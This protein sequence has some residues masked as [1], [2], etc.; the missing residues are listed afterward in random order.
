VAL[1]TDFTGVPVCTGGAL[2][3]GAP[4]SLAEREADRFAIA[5][6]FR[7]ESADRALARAR[8]HAGAPSERAAAALGAAAF[9]VGDDVFFGRNQFAPD[10]A[11]GGFLLRHELGHVQQRDRDTVRCFESFEHRAFGDRYL[12]EL[13]EFLRTPEGLAWAQ[14]MG[15][16]AAEVLAA[17][18]TD[19][20]RPGQRIHLRPG[21]DVTPGDAIALMGDFYGSIDALANAKLGELRDRPGNAAHKPGILDVIDR[22]ERVGKS[23]AAENVDYENIT[24]HRYSELARRNAQHFDPVNRTEWRRLHE[25]AIAVARA[26]RKS[27]PER[28]GGRRLR[29][30]T[31]DRRCVEP[32]GLKNSS[33]VSLAAGQAA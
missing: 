33:P 4:D 6:A 5:T 16:D 9:T 31:H 25:Q 1:R 29:S 19:P 22:E 17:I 11:E 27:A 8:I 32:V 14:S 7:P 30:R 21:V 18:R 2:R 28:V 10:T 23:T 26:S 20:G 24:H 13:Q 15:M 3:V 12:V